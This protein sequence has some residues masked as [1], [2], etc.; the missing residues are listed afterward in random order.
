MDRVRNFEALRFGMFIHFGLFSEME[1]GEWTW[2]MHKDVRDRYNELFASFNPVKLDFDAICKMGYAA[3]CR[4]ITLTMRHHDGFSLYDTR[5][6]NTYDV[7]HTPYGKDI[8]GE[9]V[10]ACRQNDIV[11]FF[12]HTTL[13]WVNPDFEKDFPKYQQYL[14]DSV[15]ILCKNYGP[16][17][18][19]WFDGN[20]SKRGAD[21]EEDALYGMIRKYQPDAILINNTGLSQRGRRGN[22]QLDTLTFEQGNL[23]DDGSRDDGRHLA[24]EACQTMNHHWGAATLDLDYKPVRT[25]IE[26]LNKCRRNDANYLLNIGLNGD[27]SVPL[28]SQ[29]ILQEIGIWTNLCKDSFYIGNRSAIVGDEKTYVLDCDSFSDVYC[30]DI[31]LLGVKNVVE[32]EENENENLRVLKNLPRKVKRIYWVDCGEELKFRQDGDVLSFHAT[33]FHYGRDLIV[34]VARIEWDDSNE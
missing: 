1:Q 11:P 22:P 19:F 26:M 24:M 18:G 17:G 30:S 12:Y 8:A 31:P 10:E 5:G 16:I 6:L 4:Y 32:S 7:M 27:G 9:F 14:R 28:M 2:L 3:G 23:Q 21:W 34:R 15:E 25:F 29:A 20:W 13:D 33:G